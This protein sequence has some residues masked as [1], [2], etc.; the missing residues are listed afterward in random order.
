M[1]SLASRHL[2]GVC[3]DGP[4][5]VEHRGSLWAT[6]I[7]ALPGEKLLKNSRNIEM[8]LVCRRENRLIA[9]YMR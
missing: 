1:I 5:R 3:A 9:I 8:R 2:F 4:V 7:F 6:E